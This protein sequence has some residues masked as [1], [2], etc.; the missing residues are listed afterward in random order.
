VAAG[1]ETGSEGTAALVD[2]WRREAVARGW[3]V[4]SLAAAVGS[5]PTRPGSAALSTT[6]T[7]G[8]AVTAGVRSGGGTGSEP[9]VMPWLARA[10]TPARGSSAWWF[11]AAA[12]AAIRVEPSASPPPGTPVAGS[13]LSADPLSADTLSADTE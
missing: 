13:P 6:G 9:F 3:E 1:T 11:A 12:E 10:A 7:P 8:D 4:P 2:R 5:V